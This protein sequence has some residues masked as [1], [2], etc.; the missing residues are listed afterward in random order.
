MYLWAGLLGIPTIRESTYVP[1]IEI[2]YL[3]VLREISI[4]TIMN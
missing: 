1:G 2:E 4:C 3:F